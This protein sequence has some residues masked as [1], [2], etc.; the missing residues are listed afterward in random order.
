MAE[1]KVYRASTGVDEFYYG[2]IGEGITAA[3][4][5]RVKFLQNINIEMPQEV[6]RAYG[7][8]RTAEMAVSN[9]DI[10]VTSAFHKIPI[11]DKQKLLGLETVEGLTAGEYRQSIIC[12]GSLC[13]DI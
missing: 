1:E 4:I 6:V 5:E 12:S 13:K 8:N 2:E 3:Y 9:G 11:E 10:S 7:D